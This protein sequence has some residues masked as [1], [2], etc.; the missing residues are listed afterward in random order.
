MGSMGC[1]SGD[2]VGS[3]AARATC[4]ESANVFSAC[5]PPGGTSGLALGLHALTL[6]KPNASSTS[7]TRLCHLGNT[8]SFDVPGH[9]DDA[10][11]CGPLIAYPSSVWWSAR[12]GEGV[13]VGSGVRDAVG[14]GE[15]YHLGVGVRVRVGGM[16]IVGVI[17]TSGG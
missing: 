11:I 7:T 1:G 4:A 17:S 12:V 14:V 2:G 3:S 5:S 13:K 16:T 6:T 9:T 8:L 15:R 10:D